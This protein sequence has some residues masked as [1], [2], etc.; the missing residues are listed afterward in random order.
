M[1][2]LPIQKEFGDIEREK[3]G[4][5][6]HRLEIKKFGTEEIAGSITLEKHR[7]PLPHYI[8]QSLYVFPKQQG[9]GFA[10]QLLEE[11]ER[12][13]RETGVPVILHDGV[14]EDQNSQAVGMYAD[15]RGWTEVLDSKESPSGKSYIYGGD[16]ETTQK[17]IE[18]LQL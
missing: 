18:L 13:S 12:I 5:S 16:E 10:T 9:K 4:R 17:F 14:K 7:E 6:G 1:E 2:K 8:A 3:W 11:V 15:L